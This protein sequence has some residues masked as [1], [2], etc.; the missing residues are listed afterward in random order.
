MRDISRIEDSNRFDDFDLPESEEK[1]AELAIYLM[2]VDELGDKIGDLAL[3]LA[4]EFSKN[5]VPYQKTDIKNGG[6][7]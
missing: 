1:R 4:H 2:F 7:K 6:E 5:L 3:E